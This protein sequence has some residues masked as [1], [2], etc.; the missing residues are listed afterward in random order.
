MQHLLSSIKTP[1]R[2]SVRNVN[3]GVYEKDRRY[4]LLYNLDTKEEIMCRMAFNDMRYTQHPYEFKNNIPEIFALADSIPATNGNR[5]YFPVVHYKMQPNDEAFLMAAPTMNLVSPGMVII[6]GVFD[7]E[8]TQYGSDKIVLS[9][10]A[11]FHS[12]KFNIVRGAEMIYPLAYKFMSH[13]LKEQA[14]DFSNTHQALVSKLSKDIVRGT[15]QHYN[16]VDTYLLAYNHDERLHCQ[17]Q[18]SLDLLIE[19]EENM[20]W[21]LK[22]HLHVKSFDNLVQQVIIK[23]ELQKVFNH[24]NNSNDVYHRQ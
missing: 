23:P 4:Q 16:H 17:N 9:H 3:V 19:E 12:E 18:E 11:R 2:L 7:K 15:E 8:Y 24:T 20:W 13:V 10:S 21:L 22:D 14:V 1:G 5:V 6:D